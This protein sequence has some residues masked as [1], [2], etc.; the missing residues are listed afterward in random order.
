MWLL[1]PIPAL[2]GPRA[3]ARAV[4]GLAY[5]AL[6][7]GCDRRLSVSIRDDGIPLCPSCQR[8][9]PRATDAVVAER[10]APLPAAQGVFGRTVALWVF[11]SGG[12]VQRL[13]HALKYRNRPALGRAY[14][15]LL[16][17]ALTHAHPHAVYDL[18]LP[19][20]L[21]RV[22]H[23]ERGYNQSHQLAH[24]LAEAFTPEPPVRDDLLLRTRPT[25]SQTALSRD[26]RWTNVADAFAVT[27]PEAVRDCRVLLVDDVLTTGAT[28]TAA[29]L[30]LRD[31]GATVDL[32]VF[33]VAAV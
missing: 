4:L 14:G 31:A 24:G 27:D 11:D 16:G 29:A 3:L 22:R 23:L 13:Q 25:R 5:P 21:S 20:P 9:L 33:A 17:Q 6:C 2:D 26:R 30:P 32:A 18:V 19:I 28:L 10:L 8:T 1:P 15:R 7:L 12:T